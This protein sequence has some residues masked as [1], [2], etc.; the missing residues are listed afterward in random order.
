MKTSYITPTRLVISTLLSFFAAG[1]LL[2]SAQTVSACPTNFICTP[3]SVSTAGAA[4]TNIFAGQNLFYGSRGPAVQKLQAFLNSNGFIVATK[5]DGSPGHETM[6]FGKATEKA[7]KQFQLQH[8]TE[9]VIGVGL[10]KPSGI[11]GPVTQAVI[12]SLQGTQVLPPP[13]ALAQ[14][15]PNAIAQAIPNAIAHDAGNTAP[16]VITNNTP[17][18]LPYGNAFVNLS[19][20]TDDPA[21][22]RYSTTAGLTYDQM[23]NGFPA[24]TV[25]SGLTYTVQIHVQ[26]L[27]TPSSSGLYTYYVRCQSTDRLV[28]GAYATDD[29][30]T[31]ISFSIAGAAQYSNNLNVTVLNQAGSITSS[32]GQLSCGR[33]GGICSASYPFPMAVTL[34]ETPNTTDWNFVFD[35]WQGPNS[36]SPCNGSSASTCSLTVSGNLTV[37][38]EFISAS[39]GGNIG[40]DVGHAVAFDGS[41]S[42]VP[43]D[44]QA[45]YT[46]DFGDGTSGSGI[47][48]SHTYSTAQTYTA[49]LTVTDPATHVSAKSAKSVAVKGAGNANPPVITNKTPAVVPYGNNIV[50]LSIMTDVNAYCTYDSQPCKPYGSQS[51]SFQSGG[52][53]SH[54]YQMAVTS[55]QSYTVYARCQSAEGSQPTNTTDTPISF[56][57]A[58]APQSTNNLTVTVLNQAGIVTSSDGQISCGYGGSSCT[59]SYDFPVPVTL[60]ETPS[61]FFPYIFDHWSAP[62]GSPCNMSTSPI[63]T[64]TITGNVGVQANYRAPQTH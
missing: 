35:H 16:P 62:T 52:G 29:S 22:C 24:N 63:C 38:A 31:A 33:L 60:T 56:S 23:G 51:S 43:A 40:A 26:G 42:V 20:R 47:T 7:L 61:T 13:N 17:S 14:N 57:V 39:A 41:A 12:A 11:F 36:T 3:I 49:T 54:T 1:T 8:S 48:T 34:T 37:G 9:L 45:T 59:A 46:W 30:D 18:V 2:A 21:Y 58:S 50:N 6:F 28:N 5:G 19:I 10:T 27:P 55:G 32:D 53:T 44:V 25:S 64:M 15:A 4:S